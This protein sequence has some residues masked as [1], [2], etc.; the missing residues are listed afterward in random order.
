MNSYYALPSN[1]L[2]GYKC[3]QC[4]LKSKFKTKEEYEHIKEHAI[5][6]HNILG[7]VYISKNFKDVAEIASSHH[8][9]YDGTGYFKGL[10]G[11]EI[12]TGA[13]VKVEAVEGCTVIVVP[14]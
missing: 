12:P 6:T 2:K 8:E 13:K 14:Q 3:K 4:Y 1:L 9:K 5:L 7:K 11:E 10:K